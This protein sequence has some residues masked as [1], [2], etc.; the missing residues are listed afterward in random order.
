MEEE[1]QFSPEEKRLLVDDLLEINRTH[2]AMKAV[3]QFE[4]I[5]NKPFDY[6][7]SLSYIIKRKKL[8]EATE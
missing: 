3:A 2:S 6:R 1:S 5:L 4:R 8:L 7:G